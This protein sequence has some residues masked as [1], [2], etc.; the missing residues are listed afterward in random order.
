MSQT[1]TPMPT[2]IGAPNSAGLPTTSTDQITAMARDVPD[3]IAKAATVDPDLASKW[4]GKALVASKTPWGTLA[5]GIVAWLASK[6]GFGWDQATT[7]L[8][9]GAGVLVMS[10]VMR[11]ISELPIT[12]FFRKAT[13]AEAAAVAK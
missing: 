13:V 11:S 4:T 9:A 10:F 8:V 7:D 12:G 6:Y 2:P 1:T 5:G 3:L